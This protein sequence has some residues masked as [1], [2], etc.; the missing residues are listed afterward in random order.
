MMF[1]VTVEEGADVSTIQ[2]LLDE[3]EAKPWVVRNS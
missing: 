1:D 2:G 3:M